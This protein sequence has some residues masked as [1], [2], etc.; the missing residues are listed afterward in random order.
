MIPPAKENAK[1]P[2]KRSGMKSIL[3]IFGG[4]MKIRVFG[5]KLI[6]GI[7]RLGGQKSA[8]RYKRRYALK[9]P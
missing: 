8:V 1:G 6:P 3:V 4:G 9:V 7:K 2:K 5:G